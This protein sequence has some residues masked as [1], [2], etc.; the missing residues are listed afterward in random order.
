[1]GMGINTTNRHGTGVGWISTV[2]NAMPASDVDS[3]EPITQLTWW[4]THHDVV[5]CDVL[6][7]CF[8]YSIFTSN[9]LIRLGHVC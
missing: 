4:F 8:N 6:A 3:H 5:A 7:D 9:F 1:M 2:T